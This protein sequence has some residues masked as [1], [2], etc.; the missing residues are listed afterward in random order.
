MILG[1]TSLSSTSLSL[2]DQDLKVVRL[3]LIDAVPV[4]G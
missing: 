1:Q 3:F 4:Q 2:H